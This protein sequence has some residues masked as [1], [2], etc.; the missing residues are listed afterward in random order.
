M[1]C[2]CEFWC[3]KVK[4]AIDMNLKFQKR[5]LKLSQIKNLNF[6]ANFGA[7]VRKTEPNK[8]CLKI[9][10]DSAHFQIRYACECCKFEAKSPTHLKNHVQCP[11]CE[12]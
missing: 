7:K 2:M 12:F 8:Q 5:K 4:I 9:H 3:E 1:Q 11:Q 10:L 6:G